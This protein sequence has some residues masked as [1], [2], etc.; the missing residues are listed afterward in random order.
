MIELLAA[1][2]IALTGQANLQLEC[3]TP[4]TNEPAWGAALPGPE[5]RIWLMPQLCQDAYL[6]GH[7]GL[8][9]LAHEILHVRRDPWCQRQGI[10]YWRCH[11][12]IYKWDDWYAENVV[13]RTL[14]TLRSANA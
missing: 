3:V 8:S 2:A 5:P 11:K 9:V 7:T 14:R 13:R 12:F 10:P 1:V 6:G 4:P